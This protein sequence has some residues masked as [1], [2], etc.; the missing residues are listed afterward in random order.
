MG[1]WVEKTHG[2]T[3]AGRPSEVVDCG[4][5]QPRLQLTSKA[6]AGGPMTDHSTQGSSE[7]K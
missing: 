3:V 6:A 4:E 5:G 1:S 7:G 2:K